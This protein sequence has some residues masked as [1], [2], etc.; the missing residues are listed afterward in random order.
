MLHLLWHSDL[1]VNILRMARERVSLL[2][3]IVL[4]AIASAKDRISPQYHGD[5][6][7]PPCLAFDT[8]KYA[9]NSAINEHRFVTAGTTLQF[10]GSDPSYARPNQ[11]VS[12]DICRMA[13]NISTSSRSGII[14]KTSLLEDWSGRFLA[15]GNWGTDGCIKYEETDYWN[16]YGFSTVG[17]DN[18]H[19]GTGGSALLR[20]EEFRVTASWLMKALLL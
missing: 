19:N 11:T 18:G 15:T 8:T 5:D 2:I 6:F 10:S 14:F 1:T 4:A 13:I 9:P 20:V 12:V 17:S 16:R 3:A 7:S